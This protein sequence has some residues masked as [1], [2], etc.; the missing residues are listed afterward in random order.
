MKIMNSASSAPTHKGLWEGSLEPVT[1]T[2]QK[3][4]ATRGPQVTTLPGACKLNSLGLESGYL[5]QRLPLPAT[6]TQ[7]PLPPAPLLPGL[8]QLLPNRER[9]P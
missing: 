9:V 3:T 4:Q 2:A 1:P 8:T 5:F 7:D 6:G